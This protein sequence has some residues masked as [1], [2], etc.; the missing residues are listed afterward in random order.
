MQ[1]GHK[2]N[3]GRASRSNI[4]EW[5]IIQGKFKLLLI[6]MVLPHLAPRVCLMFYIK[7][8]LKVIPQLGQTSANRNKTWSKFSAQHHFS[9][10]RVA[11]DQKCLFKVKNIF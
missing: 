1:H 5:G 10:A 11:I 9:C 6:P 2:C 8:I 4:P 7:A 3:P